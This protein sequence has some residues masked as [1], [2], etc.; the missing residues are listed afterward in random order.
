MATPH[1]SVTKPSI[2]VLFCGG[3]IVQKPLAS[4]GYGDV[5]PE[6]AIDILLNLNP[7]L[8][9]SYNIT[10]EYIDNIDSAAMSPN[11]WETM[12]QTIYKY[13]DDY[14]GFVITHGTHT[15]AYTASALSF[16]LQNLGKP[17]VL[18]GAPIPSSELSTEGAQNYSQAIALA[19]QNIA[20]VV[21]V[22]GEYTLL[23]TRSTKSSDTKKNAFIATGNQKNYAL[24]DFPSRHEGTL[25]IKPNF[26]SEV[27]VITLT[28]GLKADR[29]Q[30]LIQ[31]DIRGLIIRGYGPGAIDYCYLPVLEQYQ[32]LKIPVVML[33]QCREGVVDMTRYDNSLQAL[34]TGV[35]EGFD[36]SLEA[37]TTKLM[38][39]LQNY[40]YEQIKAIMQ[41]NL[42]GEIN[43]ANHV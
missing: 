35:I 24:S 7:R 22:F 18:T 11:H 31:Q 40:P 23:G 12:A 33:T 41:Q 17:V 28:P 8:N 5:A 21:I 34:E 10:I 15:M 36:L 25:Q 14:D 3:T 9:Q 42:V 20:G 19:A 39:T 13:Y 37:A 30:A 6:Q 26:C 1:T 32:S 2:L 16:A 43:S 27:E 38:W 29:L 4:G